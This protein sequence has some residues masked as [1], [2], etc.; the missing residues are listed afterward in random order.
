MIYVIYVKLCGIS[1]SYVKYHRILLS[2]T[3]HI[4]FW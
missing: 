3:V 4:S 1:C 2:W